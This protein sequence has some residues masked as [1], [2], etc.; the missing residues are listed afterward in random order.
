MLLKIP[1][2]PETTDSATQPW[3]PSYLPLHTL[4]STRTGQLA[5][6]EPLRKGE[7]RGRCREKYVPAPERGTENG[8]PSALA[9]LTWGF[10]GRP[11]TSISLPQP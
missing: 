6:P 4:S 5:R 2:L 7:W 8:R 11:K 9:C 3:A 1:A 10:W